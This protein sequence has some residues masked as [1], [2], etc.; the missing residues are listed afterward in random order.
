MKE[1]GDE[2]MRKKSGKLAGR[3][4]IKRPVRLAVLGC[5]FV[6]GITPM[7]ASAASPEFAR[8]SEEWAKLQDNI[9]EYEEIADLIHEYNVT[10]QDNQYQYN[11]F[12]KDYGRTKT[13]V[14]DG[15]RR[16]ADELESEMT[17][18]D[19][20][21]LIMDFQLEQQA[22]Q[23][24]EQ[25]DDNVEDSRTYSL[26]YSK[27]EDSLVLAAQTKFIDYY[28][29]QLELQSAKE[30][31]KRL[32]NGYALSVTQRQAGLVTETEVLDAQESV[33]EQEK[34]IANL[35]HEIE[36][37]RQ[38]LIVMCGWNG[39]DQPEISAIPEI[40]MEEINAID[41]ENDKRTAVENNYTLQIN[42][43]KLENA[44]DYDN[45]ANI[46]KTIDGNEKQIQVSVTSSWNSLQTAKMS[47]EQAVSD[48]AAEERNKQLASQKWNAGMITKYEYENQQS[49]LEMKRIAAE[50]AK[51]SLLQALENYRWDVKGL[52][53][54]E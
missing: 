19:G 41:L 50:T 17:G 44:Q 38:A 24:R 27:A 26:A 37:T 52:A 10:V 53:A 21:G 34:T 11:E 6:M 12:V 8:T 33:Q 40:N 48:E 31:K 36:N 28:T 42:K 32:E 18:E 23:L 22:K 49:V 5:A 39:N 13:D 4:A 25:A 15:Y 51:F 16:I 9:L 7:T 45:K 46:Q 20:A 29:Q 2:R 1:R 54:A 3:K 43:L 14:S 30:Q 35:E 47:Y